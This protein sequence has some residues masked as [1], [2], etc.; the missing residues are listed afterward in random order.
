MGRILFWSNHFHAVT[1]N[2]TIS[3]LSNCPFRCF[4]LVLKLSNQIAF[5][6]NSQSEENIFKTILDIPSV[7]QNQL[8]FH[9][10]LHFQHLVYSPKPQKK[11]YEL[12]WPSLER[13]FNA[14][15]KERWLQYCPTDR[16][17]A[18]DWNYK[19][20][21]R[22]IGKR[23]YPCHLLKPF[24]PNQNQVWHIKDVNWTI[25]LTF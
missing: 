16:N 13:A 4:S 8:P 14:G 2:T 24:T 19:L 1:D 23:I 10:F 5:M 20:K 12:K 18:K 7:L 15:G 11:F 3:D 22:R 9:L 21:R 25:I 6:I 17:T